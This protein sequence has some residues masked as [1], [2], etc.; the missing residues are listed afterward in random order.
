MPMPLVV[1]LEPFMLGI[2]PAS[3]APIV[4]TL[5]VVL[6]AAAYGML[7]AALTVVEDAA[8]VARMD[9]VDLHL[10]EV[11]DPLHCPLAGT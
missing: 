4:V 5:L 9:L 2:L 6:A 10:H 8:K 7:P 3:V 1:C 11:L